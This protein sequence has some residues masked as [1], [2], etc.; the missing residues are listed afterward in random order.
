M[1]WNRLTRFIQSTILKQLLILGSFFVLSINSAFCVGID[2]IAIS[3]QIAD[4]LKRISNDERYASVSI[5]RIQGNIDQNVINELIDFTNV[6]IVKS[7]AFRVID[8]S[9]LKLILNEQQFSLSGM[10][11]NDTYKELGKLMGVDLF[12]YG[13]VYNDVI[14]MKAID[15]ESSAIAWS[16]VFQISDRYSQE[17]LAIHDLAEKVINSL[18]LNIDY[19]K[20]GKIRQISFWN[21]NSSFDSKLVIDFI[22][23]SITKDRSFQIIDRENLALILKEQKLNLESVF[24]QQKA[25]KMGELYGIDAFIY[26][27]I[28]QKADGHFASLKLLNIYNGAL[29]WADAIKFSGKLMS[30][31]KDDEIV[32]QTAP[33]IKNSEMIT[34]PSGAFVMGRNEPNKLY[35]PEMHFRLKSFRI[36]R[37]E[38]SNLQYKYF[39]DKYG[40]RKPISWPGGQ[41]PRGM[42]NKPVTRI[43]WF[44]AK[45]YCT[46]MGKRL[47][48]EAE[49]EKAF[50]G[51]NGRTFPWNGN[52]FHK[53]YTRTLESGNTLP[54]DVNTMNYD[55]SHYGVMHMAGN[56]REWVGPSNN[57]FLL[58]YKGSRVKYSKFGKD[59]AIRGSSWK[60]S[61][62][63]AV[64]WYRSS[65]PANYTWDEVGF[66][67]AK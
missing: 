8:R 35:Y 67:C 54:L 4:S 37:M 6:T 18:R 31:T 29:D 3:Q 39:S 23:D 13:R 14:I 19:L 38:V 41:I 33:V 30:D 1:N 53:S 65:S 22:S 56:V 63:Y 47:P 44:D 9:K 12:I 21:I 46:M 28:T 49:W 58:P 10:V 52:R 59:K 2:T 43:N 50:R 20:N 64:G 24:D 7:R 17:T 62:S 16:D 15:V 26:G 25:K 36:D 27:N 55:V 42:E 57:S 48:T 66:R 11:T 60:L 5:S 61:R 32:E 34:I 40:H 45:R 51:P